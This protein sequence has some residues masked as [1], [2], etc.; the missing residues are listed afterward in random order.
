VIMT[1]AQAIIISH[2]GAIFVTE[3]KKMTLAR[4]EGQ[5]HSAKMSFY[6]GIL[7]AKFFDC[8]VSPA[9]TFHIKNL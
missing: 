8:R 1:T 3:S 6:S 5:G 2:C 7:N 9:G 4:V